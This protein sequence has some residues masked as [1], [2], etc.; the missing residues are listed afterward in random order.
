MMWI[1]ANLQ[2]H[3]APGPDVLYPYFLKSCAAS[4]ATPLFLLTKQ[5]LNAGTLVE[6]WKKT[7]VTPIFK[8]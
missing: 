2:K 3:K 5:S 4:L 6:L 1:Y 7:Y 8:K